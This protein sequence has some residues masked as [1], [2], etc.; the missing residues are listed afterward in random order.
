MH[1]RKGKC[2]FCEF[3]D[4]CTLRGGP[5]DTRGECLKFPDHPATYTIN[6]CGSFKKAKRREIERRRIMTKK[7][8]ARGR[9]KTLQQQIN[10]DRVHEYKEKTTR[11]NPE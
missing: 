6:K 3:W 1:W 7:A 9:P 11:G 8:L 4:S 10:I 5:F 2:E